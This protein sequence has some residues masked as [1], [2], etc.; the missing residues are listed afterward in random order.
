MNIITNMSIKLNE[1]QVKQIITD[2]VER[3]TKRKVTKIYVNVNAGDRG[4][5]Q[6]E[7][8]VPASLSNITVELGDVI[9]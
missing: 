6:F 4:F 9:V 1:E 3:E 5:S 2:A 7:P 8:F